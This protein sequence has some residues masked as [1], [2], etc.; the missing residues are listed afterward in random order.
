[1]RRADGVVRPI[2]AFGFALIA[3]SI[4][5]LGVFTYWLVSHGI[6]G[7]V[8]S[9]GFYLPIPLFFLLHVLGF[10]TGLGVVRFTKWGYRLFSI[11]LYV[12]LFAFPIGTIAAYLTFSY[13]KRHQIAEYYGLQT[14]AGRSVVPVSR[15]WL[16]VG[17]GAIV[18]LYLWMLFSF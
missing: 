5:S 16:L 7:K 13:M 10:A 1:M 12:L 14:D 2:R 15:A 9:I 18:A 11:F 17:I 6:L 3:L 4:L 8:I